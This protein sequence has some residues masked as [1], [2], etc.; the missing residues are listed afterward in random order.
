MVVE[1]EVFDRSAE[2]E[3]KDQLRLTTPQVRIENVSDDI[4]QTAAH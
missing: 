4:R 2:G 1:A 3:L